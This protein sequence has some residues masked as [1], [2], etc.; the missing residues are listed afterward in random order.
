MIRRRDAIAGLAAG[1]L[2]AVN[3]C[4]P[5]TTPKRDAIDIAPGL[6]LIMPSPGSLGRLVEADQLVVARYRTQTVAFEGRVS[7]SAERF[8]LLC[9]DPFGRKAMRIRWTDA[10]IDGSKATGVPADLRPENVLADLVMLY[11]PAPVVARALAPSGGM[12]E[13]GAAA[14]SVRLRGAEVIHAAF[15]PGA[16]GD[17]WNGSVRY[18]NLPL[19]YE[20]T[21]Q[22]RVL[23]A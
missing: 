10:G 15:Q 9:I 22:S 8:D 20:L 18:R 17:P 7:A 2:L 16:D 14:R 1:S 4:T 23:Q 11:W 6:S 3:A 5:T 21:I 13:A 19:D 12:L